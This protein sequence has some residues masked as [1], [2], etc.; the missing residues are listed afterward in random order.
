MA[1]RV[2]GPTKKINKATFT[3]ESIADAWYCLA[4]KVTKFGK[5]AACKERL[6]LR[7]L[8]AQIVTA[9]ESKYQICDV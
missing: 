5:H 1:C 7:F 6:V 4:V 9:G 8:N 3:E 2:G